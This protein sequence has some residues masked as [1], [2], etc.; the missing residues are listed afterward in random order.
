[1][2]YFFQIPT[3]DLEKRYL[4]FAGP[5]KSLLFTDNK[6]DPIPGYNVYPQGK[7]IPDLSQWPKCKIYHLP[8]ITSDHLC[9][10]SFDKGKEEKKLPDIFIFNPWTIISEKVRN[11]IEEVD[12][13]EHQFYPM[14]FLDSDGKKID[15]GSYFYM[16]IRCQCI[17][18]PTERP[19]KGGV[20][21]GDLG[22]QLL[23]LTTAP[24]KL[25]DQ[26]E[27]LAIWQFKRQ[28]NSFFF[29]KKLNDRFKENK[30]TGLDEDHSDTDYRS[31]KEITLIR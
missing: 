10:L 7:I 29:S 24:E 27:D 26:V 16:H 6:L 15:K 1:M 31:V 5:S 22:Y 13:L 28:Q 17:V 9:S 14:T 25:I 3:P 12:D 20:G 18:P 4:N 23:T 30:I 8:E 21:L 19:G 11:I 2:F